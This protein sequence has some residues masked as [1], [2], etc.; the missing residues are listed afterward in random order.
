MPDVLLVEDDRLLGQGLRSLLGQQGYAAIWVG[1]LRTAQDELNRQN[2]D[3]LLLDVRLPDG[4]GVDFCRE[5]R[6]TDETPII[7]L[8]A[9]DEDADMVRGLDAG[10][11]DYI[12]KPFS[13]GVLLSRIR[14]VLRRLPQQQSG[15]VKSG[16][17][18]VKP[19][20]RRVFL[21]ESEQALTPIEYSLL[22][23]LLYSKGRAMSRAVLLQKVWEMGGDFVEDNTLSVYMLRLRRKL[24]DETGQPVYI[25]TLRGTGYRW[26]PQVIQE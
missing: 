3:L 20:Q 14:A 5:L 11:D 9:C 21:G 15:N 1:D 17:I 22:M 13:A 23:V 25:K 24:G 19:D 8:T 12:A 4:N 16:K 10:A 18:T 6:K 7:F 2:F 26:L